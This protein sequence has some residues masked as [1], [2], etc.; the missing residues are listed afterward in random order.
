MA[1][2]RFFDGIRERI[3][4]PEGPLPNPITRTVPEIMTG[5]TRPLQE[6]SEQLVQ[7]LAQDR[8]DATNREAAQQVEQ[9]FNSPEPID[10]L[11]GT[12]AQQGALT[13]GNPN[14][15]QFRTVA[16]RTPN[17]YGRVLE[18]S[19]LKVVETSPNPQNVL[20]Q[21]TNPANPTHGQIPQAI[22][23][24]LLGGPGGVPPPTHTELRDALRNRLSLQRSLGEVD[25]LAAL[26]RE[27]RAGN[28]N[29]PNAEFNDMRDTVRE[30]ENFLRTEMGWDFTNLGVNLA[31]APAGGR[32]GR[33]AAPPGTIIRAPSN[34]EDAARVREAGSV[35]YLH[36]LQYHRG[37]Q[38]YRQARR[39]RDQGVITPQ[40]ATARMQ[41]AE[42][43]ANNAWI[44]FENALHEVKSNVLHDILQR[45]MRSMGMTEDQILQANDPRRFGMMIAADV[46][47]LY[48]NIENMRRLEH[49]PIAGEEFEIRERSV[50]K[51]MLEHWNRI[52]APLRI[53]AGFGMS[54]VVL[55]TLP[56]AFGGL[57]A[58]FPATSGIHAALAAT[59]NFLG[60]SLLAKNGILGAAMLRTRS[61]VVGA[62]IYA[63]GNAVL[64]HIHSPERIQ[65]RHNQELQTLLQ[66]SQE[67]LL[68][69][70]AARRDL[71]RQLDENRLKMRRELSDKM[72][73]RGRAGLLLAFI[74]TPLLTAT[75]LG[76]FDAATN[77]WNPTKPG[78]ATPT[79]PGTGVGTHPPG[80][81]TGAHPP[82]TPA[83]PGSN[84][85]TGPSGVNPVDLA[86][87]PSKFL[88]AAEKVYTIRSGDNFGEVLKNHNVFGLSAADKQFA[89]DHS[90]IKSGLDGK[91]Y[92]IN[93]VSLT[94]PGDH[95]H[96]M[97]MADGYH[98]VVTPDSG[99][100]LGHTAGYHN[101][102]VDH[103]N[104]PPAWMEKSVHGHN[105][106]HFPGSGSHPP[107]DHG[108]GVG[109][110]VYGGDPYGGNVYDTGSITGHEKGW[111]TVEAPPAQ[112]GVQSPGGA[113]QVPEPAATP[114]LG[115][116]ERLP[117]KSG[118]APFTQLT[119]DQ[120]IGAAK[121]GVS[122]G[123]GA[124][125]AAQA[126][127]DEFGRNAAHHKSLAGV[128]SEHLNKDVSKNDTV[129]QALKK[130]N[131]NP[132]N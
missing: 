2:G 58:L 71:M 19:I 5:F 128:L 9:I 116:P 111:N 29:L 14:F 113:P 106:N 10:A 93:G 118:L 129:E 94:H 43:F 112:G 4:G 95:V 99:Q 88:G 45:K 52:P 108:S 1:F 76:L 122:A 66:N 85:N 132:R 60:G 72:K 40:E 79:A 120:Y 130:L 89:W 35:A 127:A 11:F 101:I 125:T 61:M 105:V 54:M 55:T 64:N 131:I 86:K 121:N 49:L 13:P 100:P 98:Y 97:K 34:P 7:T 83:V 47:R 103:G 117:S 82:G 3:V 42:A 63:L 17:F 44:S 68:R 87:D 15:A 16:M 53:A 26:N 75:T 107:I 20:D 115:Q 80:T 23:N 69:D 6:R 25:P 33:G 22:R 77:A 51:G 59:G 81:G 50:W 46:N 38:Q 92:P 12:P 18:L 110:K 27:R 114:G 126:Q 73:A 70:P 24:A 104:Q 74:L 62:G 30:T 91:I 41:A 109:D 36:R 78:V 37:V 119:V 57:A 48:A 31:A 96:L 123:I 84:I 65:Q 28:I 56:A 102:V 8:F 67:A 124:D 21:I 32:A 90:F 39:E